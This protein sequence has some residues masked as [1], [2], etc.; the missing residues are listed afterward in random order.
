MGAM[1][2]QITSLMIVR[3][4]VYSDQR[5]YQSSTSLAYVRGIHRWPVNSPHKFPVTRKM[6]PFDD[7]RCACCNLATTFIFTRLGQW[8]HKSFVI[9]IPICG[10]WGTYQKTIDNIMTSP[11]S[12][13][14]AICAG[15]SPVTKGQWRRTLIFYFDLRL[16]KRLSKQW[17]GW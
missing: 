1:A 8:A 11:F 13:L 5:K 10:V 3:S 6:F 9:W 12:A 7:D 2:S 4:T 14:L 17:R 16:K 15:N